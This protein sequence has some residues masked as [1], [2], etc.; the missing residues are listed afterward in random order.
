VRQVPFVEGH[1]LDADDPFVDF[2]LR[3]PIDEEE[4][5]AVQK[6]PF[7]RGVIQR[8]RQVHGKEAIILVIS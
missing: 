4:R 1:V 3:D 8:Q 7:N 6:N 5:I 2:E